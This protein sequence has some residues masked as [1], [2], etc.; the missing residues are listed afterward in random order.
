MLHSYEVVLENHG[1]IDCEYSLSPNNSLFASRFSFAPARGHLKS[2]Q[3]QIVEVLFCSDMLGDFNEAFVWYLAGQP[4]P[5]PLNL[6]GRVVGPQ[7]HFSLQDGVNFG[8]GPTDLKASVPVPVTGT[9][10][11]SAL[12]IASCC[13]AQSP[14]ASSNR[15][16]FFCTTLPRFRCVSVSAFRL[17]MASRIPSLRS[18][19]QQALFYL[20]ANRRSVHPRLLHP[21]QIDALEPTNLQVRL[22]FISSAVQKYDLALL[23]DVEAVGDSLLS[24]PI[25]AECVVPPIQPSTFELDFGDAFVGYTYEQY[26]KIVNPSY[27]PA[28]CEV[29]AAQPM[30]KTIGDYVAEPPRCV[31]PAGGTV[32]VK[33]KFTAAQLGQ[34]SLPMYVRIVGLMDPAFTV[35]LNANAIG[36]NVILSAKKRESW[37]RPSD[38]MHGR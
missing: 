11:G 18:C 1:D 14:S 36:P 15:R 29:V 25:I 13:H 4:E 24:L 21:S 6:K 10:L 37:H 23:V 20:M 34:M 3:Q 8:T 9:V 33:I 27:L 16:P 5:L 28:K 7:F 12:N 38:A 31:V 30:L 35:E 19:R 32:E 22:D 17:K 26:I 2:R